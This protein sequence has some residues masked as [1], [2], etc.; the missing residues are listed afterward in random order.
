[1]SKMISVKCL[2]KLDC[3][4]VNVFPE[5]DLVSEVPLVAKDGSRQSPSPVEFDKTMFVKCER[6]GYPINCADATISD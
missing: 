3:G 2:N 6:C 1:M 4:H 5:S